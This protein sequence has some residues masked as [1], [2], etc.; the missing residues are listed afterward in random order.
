MME[1]F[2]ENQVSLAVWKIDEI[3]VDHLLDVNI[4]KK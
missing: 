1:I 3:V 4:L 2:M